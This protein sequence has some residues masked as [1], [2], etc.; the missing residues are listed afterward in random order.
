MR[1][2]VINEVSTVARNR[3]IVEALAGSG[4]EIINAGMRPG[5]AGPELTYIHIG[6]LSALL[7]N[8]KRVGFVVAGCGTG[9]G[10]Q[11]SVEQFPNVFCG[12]LQTPLDAWLFARINAGNCVSL[13][14]NQGYGWGADVNLRL[15]FEQLF[16]GE[17]ADGYPSHRRDS[18]QQSR[19]L[20]HAISRVT[21]RSMAEIVHDLD[22]SVVVPVLEHPGVWD[23][24]DVPTLEDRAL[25]EALEF[26]RCGRAVARLAGDPVVGMESTLK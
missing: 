14:L 24:L 11:T 4:H 8:S 20:L 13:A 2:A 12:H 17:I 15:V 22:N 1:V 21:H 25:A 19:E 23:L 3:D 10:F 26:R 16:G 5:C 18:Q 7:L 9:Q 6:F